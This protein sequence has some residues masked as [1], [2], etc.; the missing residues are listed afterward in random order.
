MQYDK[1]STPAIRIRQ[2]MELRDMKAVDLASQTGLSNSMISR[3]LS[4]EFEPKQKALYKIGTVLNVTEMWLAGYD[5]PMD[6]TPFQIDQAQRVDAYNDKLIRDQSIL[7]KFNKLTDE[8]QSLVEA[9]IDQL[10]HS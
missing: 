6:R 3:Y 1:V 7:N 9:L 8:Q 4:G 10:L 2:A 5:I